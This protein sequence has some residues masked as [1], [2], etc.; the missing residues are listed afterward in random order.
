MLTIADKGGKVVRQILLPTSGFDGSGW[1]EEGGSRHV[2]GCVV[3]F[4][5][6]YFGMERELL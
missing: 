2:Q 6:V 4:V 3:Y 1:S 5:V